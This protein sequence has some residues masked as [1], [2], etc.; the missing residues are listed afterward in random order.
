MEGLK[1]VPRESHS[2]KNGMLPH[3]RRFSFRVVSALSVKVATRYSWS[4]PTFFSVLSALSHRKALWAAN[5]QQSIQPNSTPVCLAPSWTI[6]PKPWTR[7]KWSLTSRNFCCNTQCDSAK[8]LQQ[9]YFF[10]YKNCEK[11]FLHW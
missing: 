6:V 11:K 1:V 5:S 8:Y 4:L 7:G 3:Y 9:Y 2:F 10:F